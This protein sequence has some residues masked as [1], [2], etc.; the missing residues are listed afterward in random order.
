VYFFSGVF[1]Y[2]APRLNHYI[3]DRSVSAI[4]Y[5][6][7]KKQLEGKICNIETVVTKGK[8]NSSSLTN[9]ALMRKYKRT[10]EAN[11]EK[12]DDNDSP[13][14][15]DTTKMEDSILMSSKK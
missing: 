2:L 7:K 6:E 8:E 1:D 5:N 14:S 11:L 12:D 4:V 9:S 10:F 3:R 13:A 15:R